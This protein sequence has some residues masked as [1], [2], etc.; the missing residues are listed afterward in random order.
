MFTSLSEY[1]KSGVVV[2]AAGA[3]AFW[4]LSNAGIITSV[5]PDK[6]PAHVVKLE[7]GGSIL[8]KKIDT[9]ASIPDYSNNAVQE[10]K[11]TLKST[12]GKSYKHTR[13]S[14]VKL[15]NKETGQVIEAAMD[16][17]KAEDG[18]T[19]IVLSQPDAQKEQWDVQ[20]LD[21]VIVPDTA[22][23]AKHSSAAGLYGTVDGKEYG[24]WYDKDYSRARVGVEVGVQNAKPRVALKV[25]FTF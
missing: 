9:A 17:V 20:G 21:T 1:I 16:T 18:T 14:V 13:N 4:A 8:E 5:N 22:P 19:R 23:V 11:S 2:L 24:I 10:A 15:T 6:V 25:G 3:V 7:S 12:Q